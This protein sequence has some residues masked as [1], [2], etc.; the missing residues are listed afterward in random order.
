MAS[1]PVIIQIPDP[2]LPDA[3]FP[4][5]TGQLIYTDINYNIVPD[6]SNNPTYVLRTNVNNNEFNVFQDSSAQ[7]QSFIPNSLLFSDASLN[8]QEPNGIVR[9]DSGNFYVANGG[10]NNTISVYNSNTTL[11][12]T[13]QLGN[14]DPTGWIVVRYLALDSSN[15]I[16]A[17]AE[18]VPSGGVAKV[19]LSTKVLTPILTSESNCRGLAYISGYL[20]V[21]VKDVPPNAYVIKYNLTTDNYVK[22]NLPGAT[23]GNCEPIAIVYNTLYTGSPVPFL[24]ITTIGDPSGNSI[25]SISEITGT[26]SPSGGTGSGTIIKIATFSDPTD[27]LFGITLDNSGNIYNSLYNGVG[28]IARVIPS[29]TISN[30]SNVS[31]AG[32]GLTNARGLIFDGSLNLYVSDETNNRILNV[33]PKTFVFLSLIHI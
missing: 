32:T 16:Y 7:P 17:T 3:L 10:F 33:Q 14:L 22:L 12:D 23:I 2:F 5:N 11:I 29:G 21:V 25:Y 1:N 13:I 28:K 8:N 9:D 15:N 26:E 19:N 20:Y 30:V 18:S 6:I 31:Y 24:Y 27:N 4:S